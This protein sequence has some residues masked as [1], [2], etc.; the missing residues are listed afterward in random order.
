MAWRE[1]QVIRKGGAVMEECDYF[2]GAVC[3]LASD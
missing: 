3:L 2:P 1:V